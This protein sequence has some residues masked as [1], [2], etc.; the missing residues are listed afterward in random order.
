MPAGLNHACPISTLPALLEVRLKIPPTFA[1]FLLSCS[2][3][4]QYRKTA[5]RDLRLDTCCLLPIPV[6][7]ASEPL[8][9]LALPST[10][11]SSDYMHM[12]VFNS[13]QVIGYLQQR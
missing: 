8:D 6:W 7:N 10:L 11:Q 13:S 3:S 4:S 1:V 12:P 2:Y 5:G 9:T